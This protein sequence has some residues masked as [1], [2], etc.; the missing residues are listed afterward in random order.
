M[1]REKDYR[2]STI[3]RLNRLDTN[4]EI[5]QKYSD[6][7][8]LTPGEIWRDKKNGHRVGVLDATKHTDIEKLFSGDTSSC[9]IND[10]PYNVAVGKSN[11]KM[12]FKIGLNDYIDFSRGWITN[13]QSVMSRDT[14]FYLWIGAD[15]KDNFQPLPDIMLLLREFPNLVPRNYITLRNQ[16]GYGTQKNWM[17]IRQ[18]LLHYT[19]GNPFFKVQYTDIPKVLKGYYKTVKGKRTENL[20]RSKSDYI[21]PGNVWIDIQQVFYRMKENVPGCYAQ[22]PLKAIERIIHTSS[23]EGDIIADFFAHSGTTL[24]AGE[25]HKRK[26]YTSDIDPLYA[27]I[28]IRRLE[29]FRKTREPGWQWNSP[30]PEIDEI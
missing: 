30:F 9:F 2:K 4:P 15:Y 22:K 25:M 20:E 5:R 28:T 27:E 26:V 18:E 6:L 24:I 23:R 7:C 10:P 12:L 17:W 1:N 13:T 14:H 11:S 21:R 19:T 3:E 16:R 29:H 8:R